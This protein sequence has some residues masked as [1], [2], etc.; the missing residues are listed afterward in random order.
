MSHHPHHAQ[1]FNDSLR[2]NT[3]RVA[4][5]YNFLPSQGKEGRKESKIIRMR[6]FNNWIKS[7]LISQYC[8]AGTSILDI[9]GGKGGDLQKWSRSRVGH[10]VL[11]DVALTSVHQAVSRY[12]EMRQPPFRASFIAADCFRPELLETASKQAPDIV[13]PD[14]TF[15]LVSCMF[16]LHYSFESEERARGFLSNVSS[17]L[18]PGGIFLGTLPDCNYLVKKARLDGKCEFGNSV[19]NVK[20]DIKDDGDN[21]M[22]EKEKILFHQFPEFGARYTFYLEDAVGGVPEYLVHFSVLSRLAAEYDL[23]LVR[24]TPFHQFYLE[25]VQHLEHAELLHR[26]KCLDEEGTI[27]PDEWEAIALYSVFVFEK[28]GPRMP[29]TFRRGARHVDPKDVIVVK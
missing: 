19:Y 3:Q 11:A 16:S 28:I 21:P 5:H 29:A 22:D 20:F 27:S 26:M 2:G 24:K 7:C 1:S 23:K 10:V 14:L 4:D 8:R 25:C 13:P 9:C 18:Q 15:D 12:N 17:R 6:N